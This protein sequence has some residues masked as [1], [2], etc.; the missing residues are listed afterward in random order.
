[1][2]KVRTSEA[3]NSRRELWEQIGKRLAAFRSAKGMSLKELSQATATEDP[4][5]KGISPSQLLKYEKAQ[6]AADVPDLIRARWISRALEV[7]VDDLVGTKE[8]N[9]HLVRYSTAR[10]QLEETIGNKREI[11]RE[12]GEHAHFIKSG[13]Y[14]YVEID[15][16][17]ANAHEKFGRGTFLTQAY[18]F[19]VGPSQIG[20][21]KV[22]ATKREV[23]KVLLDGTPDAGSDSQRRE[24]HSGEELI[25]VLQGELEF[26]FLDRKDHD[27]TPKTFTLRPFD[28]A[29]YSSTIPHA[30]RSDEGALALFV[31][32]NSPANTIPIRARTQLR[33]TEGPDETAS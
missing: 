1:M 18:L 26:S 12:S 9:V 32:T 14:R 13:H 2:P 16:G 29:Q 22:P 23:L 7:S 31:Y 33:A 10:H 30:Y 25:C 3:E 21:G 6:R 27:W 17:Q 20:G 11:I 8:S 15:Y 28:T 4:E 5:R 19:W 24:C